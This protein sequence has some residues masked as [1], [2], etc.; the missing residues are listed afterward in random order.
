M[1]PCISAHDTGNVTRAQ[2][3]A[4]AILG[5]GSRS[6]ERVERKRFDRTQ[7]EVLRTLTAEQQDPGREADRAVIVARDAKLRARQVPLA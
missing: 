5:D 1:P 4:R 2:A 3:P 6:R 7:R